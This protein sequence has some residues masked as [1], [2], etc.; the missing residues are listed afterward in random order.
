[1]KFLSRLRAGLLQKMIFWLLFEIM[2]T[3]SCI[4]SSTLIFSMFVEAIFDCSV[5][6]Y[7]TPKPDNNKLNRTVRIIHA[8]ENDRKSVNF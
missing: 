5:E 1:M 4:L 8:M 6:R 2:R 7:M 3:P